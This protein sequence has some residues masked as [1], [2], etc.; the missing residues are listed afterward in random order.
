[1]SENT[2]TGFPAGHV[3]RDAAALRIGAGC[4]IIGAIA[5]GIVRTMHGDT[6][7]VDAQASL[8]F[9]AGRPW[10]TAVHIAAVFAAL[11]TLAGLLAL[12]GTLTHAGARMLGGLGMASALVGLAVFSVESTSEGLALPELARAAATASP[13]QRVELVRAAQAVLSVTHGP[14]LVAMATL[15]GAPLVLYG[16]AIVL[17]TYPSWLGWA[18]T[19][20][21]TVTLIAATAQYLHPDLMPGFLIYG[22]LGSIVAQAWLIALAVVMLRRASAEAH[23]GG[24]GFAGRPPC[25]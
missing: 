19:V 10:Y 14:S 6:P 7:G 25:P 16:L 8:T 12:A 15:Y 5:F 9:V 3:A 18:G 22:V 17:D 11:L 24:D 4:T 21:G 13:E 1:M 23:S 2:R 20:V